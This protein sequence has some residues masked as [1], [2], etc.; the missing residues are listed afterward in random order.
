MFKVPSLKAA[1]RRFQAVT[2][3]LIGLA[4]GLLLILVRPASAIEQ[5]ELRLLDVQTTTFTLDRP[6]DE[7][8]VL[9]EIT[10]SD[11]EVVRKA[12][13]VSWPWPLSYNA[14]AFQMMAEAG[15]AAVM[16]DMYHFDRGAGPDD[17][18]I[19]D[20]ELSDTLR[21][22]LTEESEMADE[23]GDAMRSV[24]S[25]ALAF[26][27]AQVA[28][29]HVEA[30]F[31]AALPRLACDRVVGGPDGVVRADAN[32]PVRRVTEGARLLGFANVLEDADG[33]VRRAPVLGRLGERRVLSLPLA[34]QT[35]LMKD[36]VWFDFEG[37]HVGDVV[38]PVNEDGSFVVN[39]HG[40]PGHT[41]PR[42]S[43]SQILLWAR[44][45]VLDGKPVPEEARQALEGKVV[46]W[47]LNV[48]GLQDI[49]TSP[50][51]G[52]MHGPEF[53]A[54]VLDNLAHGD[55]R[56][57][58][59]RGYNAIVLLIVTVSLG[60]LAGFLK[61]RWLLHLTPMIV[62]VVGFSF[63]LWR[64]TQGTAIDVF[65]PLLGVILTWGGTTLKHML[66]S[67]R[68]NRW[69]EGTFG[70]YLAPSIIEA[71][72]EDPTLLKL[73][74][75]KRELTILFSDIAGFTSLTEKLDEHQMV[76]LLNKYLTA[77]SAAV[78]E[79][80]GV[81]DKFIGDAVMAFFGDPV[82]TTA[83]AV[84]GCRTALKVQERIPTL[85]PLWESMGLE[86][87][88]VRIG[89]NSG[90]ATVGNMGS[91]QRFAYTCMGDNVNLASRLEGAN[92]AFG[93]DILIGS[94]TYQEAKD[95]IVAKP[96]G[97]LVVVGRTKPEPVYVLHAMRE[98]APPDLVAHVEAFT[99]AQAAARAGD[100][101]AARKALDEAA[102]L[103][104]GDGPTAWFRRILD[105]MESGEEPTPW[106]GIVV[107]KG[108]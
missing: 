90:I 107:L 21:A 81:V 83:H 74:G 59:S 47:G 19:P 106:S 43:P 61:R 101:E 68:R 86:K 72:K 84:Q 25:V 89:L 4:A 57:R 75:Q 103:R 100:L 79:E 17:H 6:P 94:R 46:V 1:T 91:D 102:A 99:R 49:V 85:R 77:H 69:L 16:V 38:Q 93:S 63:A 56:I 15:V 42:V 23:Y 40:N 20:E 2:D 5:I 7:R 105:A 60:L 22:K 13:E 65:T 11:L 66:T 78:M 104:A 54:T 70:S 28:D 33:V 96:I 10:E 3:G 36:A 82:P 34:C 39:F 45:V 80:G 62:L 97:G 44:D 30:R 92:K 51:S 12:F 73:G 87:F 35:L 88:Q 50:T 24:G 52:R 29:Y 108:K 41:Y 53:Q 32:F 67:G 27:L 71:L 18:G 55:G 8:I 31:D 37:L 48:A 76:E 14:A 95:A 26:E 64:F 98:G 9:S 58:A